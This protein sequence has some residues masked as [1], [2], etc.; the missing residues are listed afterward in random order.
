MR[1]KLA[2]I[3]PGG[4]KADKVPVKGETPAQNILAELTDETQGQ[5]KIG[6]KTYDAQ[7]LRTEL[8][9]AQKA[10][11]LRASITAYDQQNKQLRQMLAEAQKGAPRGQQRP[12]T[13]PQQAQG[14]TAE[15]FLHAFGEP[16]WQVLRE[17]QA[18][19]PIQAL[20]Y[21]SSELDGHVGSSIQRRME[22]LEAKVIS[23]LEE[24]LGKWGDPINELLTDRYTAQINGQ[25]VDLFREARDVTRPDGSYMYPALYDEAATTQI[26]TLWSQIAQRNPDAAMTAD[27]FRA[28][29][30]QWMELNPSWTPPEMDEDQDS[31][32]SPLLEEHQ[33]AQRRAASV[34]N[35][36]RSG[37]GPRSQPLSEADQFLRNVRDRGSDTLS[38]FG[39]GRRR[40]LR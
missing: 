31:Q 24:R 17:L 39:L 30:S 19:D 3:P 13:A 22:A 4:K 8:G 10:K 14:E 20:A 7:G 40:S 5:V 27:A 18:K 9:R 32:P 16:K 35:A 25:A 12:Q 37:M 23:A 33:E 26:A 15:D 21:L 6:D 28:A 2:P 29:Y 34:T 38:S 11:E 36:T 1:R